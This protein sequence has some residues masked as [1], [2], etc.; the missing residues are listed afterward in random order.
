MKAV[1]YARFSST[2][3]RE[4]SI[5]GQI[6]ECQS[7]AERKGLVVIQTYCDRAISGKTDNRPQFQQ[8]IA[9]SKNGLFDV[10]LVWKI[11]RFSRDK[12]DS[13][14]YKHAL[15]KNG[16]SVISATEPIDDSPEGQLMESIFEGFSV[17]Y[18][19]DLSQK[20]NRGLTENALKLKFNGGTVTFGYMI[21]S[22]QH[23]QVHPENALIVADIFNRYASGEPTKSICESVKIP[24]R[25]GELA[26]P[27]MNFVANMLK[28]RRYLGEYK[29][30]DIVTPSAFEPIITQEIFDICQK[31]LNV[32]KRKPARFKAVDERY[33]L[34]SKLFCGKCG[35]S[36]AGE[37][38]TSKTG[39]M[40]RYYKCYSAKRR[41]GC[42]KKAVNKA[43]IEQMV[44]DCTMAM[45]D[46]EELIQRIVGACFNLQNKDNTQLPLL[47]QRLA[48]VE[49]QLENLMNAILQGITSQ[50]TKD[51][52]IRLENEKED[53]G[54]EIV[55]ESVKRP[56]LSKEQIKL[57]IDK[58]AVTNITDE[59][60]KQKLIDVFVN[61]VYVY[62]DKMVIFFNY[63]DGEKLVDFESAKETTNPNLDNHADC[64]SSSLSR[65]GRG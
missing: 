41:R 55:K 14:V 34:S 25:K 1:I 6:R 8:M 27:G 58:F 47:K 24:N 13:V 57:W 4:E 19:K 28:N 10:V 46:D 7:F 29:F 42:D 18:I 44:F 17:Y 32:N 15:K 38:G 62:D 60:Q 35:E 50:T 21:D 36:M 51:T 56:I 5:E 20:V 53:L 9:D 2:G 63:K 40:H 43:L 39:K 45:F 30:Q 65:F 37:S 52:L 48:E 26:N 22:D 61:S 33:I 11:D 59:Q 12:Y 23:F 31:R 49:K 54:L 64:Q 16:V 3:Q